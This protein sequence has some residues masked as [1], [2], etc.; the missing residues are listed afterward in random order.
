MVGSALALISA[1]R[2]R[3]NRFLEE[4]MARHGLHG[5]VTSH[6]NI[7]YNLFIHKEM[8]MKEL[9]RVTGKDKSTITALVNK[10][11]DLGYVTRKRDPEDQRSY[12]VS[13]TPKGA[14]MEKA[15]FQISEE[16]MTTLY[17]GISEEEQQQLVALLK[18][19]KDN[20]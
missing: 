16:L 8:S 11:L 4:Q 13:L 20:F 12:C 7:L 18:R 14:A 2:D 19:I 10:L 15:F 17:R 3:A 6:G 1:I 9:S 5:L